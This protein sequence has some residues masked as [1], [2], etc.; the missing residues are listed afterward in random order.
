MCESDCMIRG[1]GDV[2]LPDGCYAL[3]DRHLFGNTDGWFVRGRIVDLRKCSFPVRLEPG[4]LVFQA[5]HPLHRPQLEDLNQL[6]LGICV[7]S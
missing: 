1:T 5:F 7:S 6:F 2:G 4:D 3:V